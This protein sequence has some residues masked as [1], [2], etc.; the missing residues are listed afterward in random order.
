[1]DVDL[2]AVVF[3]ADEDDDDVPLILLLLLLLLMLLLLLLLPV[4]PV[5]VGGVV[6][7][8]EFVVKLTITSA[9]CS[10]LPKSITSLSKLLPGARIMDEPKTKPLLKLKMRV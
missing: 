1:M 3:A 4:P 7:V 10:N 9:G 5:L 2:T 8:P 6:V